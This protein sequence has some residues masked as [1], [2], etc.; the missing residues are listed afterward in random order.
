MPTEKHK[1]KKRFGKLT[2]VERREYPTNKGT[3]K[4][5]AKCLCDCGNIKEI[6]VKNLV[7]GRTKSCGCSKT[8][9]KNLTGE[10]SPCF[11]GYKDI[12]KTYWNKLAKRSEL[13][14]QSFSL[15]MKQGWELFELQ[16]R[17]CALTGLPI[18]FD[19]CNG[20]TTASLDRINTNKG[21]EVDNVQWVHKDVNKMRN[22]Y[23][24]EY[25]IKICKLVA[26]NHP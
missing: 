9:Y 25:F 2:V 14:E 4:Y 10:K 17:K 7:N 23:T 26:T 15:T 18:V 1:L 6:L 13:R 5:M 12:R 8:H 20:N 21:Y 22:V 16:N 3:N 24:I 11:K 19:K